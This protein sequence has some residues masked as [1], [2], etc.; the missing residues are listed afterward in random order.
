MIEVNGLNTLVKSGGD[1]DDI[2]NALLAITP[3]AVDQ[4]CKSNFNIKLTGN[5]EKD[6][7]IVA[8]WIK[9]NIRYK[10]DGYQN[11]NIKLAGRLIKDGFGD[12]KSFA[13]LFN[14]IMSK[15]GYKTGYRFASYRKNKVPTHVYN[16]VL[17]TNGKKFIF[18]ACSK[19][20]TESNKHTFTKDMNINYLSGIDTAGIYGKAE[21]EARKAARK[22]KRAERKEKGGGGRGKKILLAPVRGAFLSLVGLNVRGLAT[23]L[24]ES[25]Q[26]D[27]NTVQ[28]FWERVG[29]KFEKLQKRVDKSK[30]KKAL[31]G[32]KK[33]KGV[34]GYEEFIDKDSYLSVAGVDDAAVAAFIASAA[35]VL[36]AA[37]KLFKKL[38]VNK[39][40]GDVVK[41]DEA[42]S[43]EKL[44]AD[45][46]ADD[47]ENEGK[48][49]S[50][51]T[52]GFKPSPLL[53]G[54]GIAALAAIYFI[55]K[56]KK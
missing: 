25:I 39:G 19:T 8:K 2:I 37:S 6:G 41:E 56:K 34:N 43:G 28:K 14:C 20:L 54:G 23:K 51:D 13:L 18:D 40:E 29:G 35:P 53:I 30:N 1:T 4:V 9:E 3:K 50:G 45:F 48:G 16:Y 47:D 7:F 55:T 31:F 11:Q 5:A 15:N 33:G 44:P 32:K 46:Q 42:A 38:G 22:A 49:S 52:V 24:A 36:V 17:D 12:C 10:Q 26:K 27:N 21:R